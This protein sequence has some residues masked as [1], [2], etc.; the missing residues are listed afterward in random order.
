MIWLRMSAFAK[1]SQSKLIRLLVK[2]EVGEF[3]AMPGK[4]F[5]LIKLELDWILDPNQAQ[6]I[7]LLDRAA[8]SVG[9]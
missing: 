7:S 1:N 3:E 5:T 6:I 4:S 2:H 8:W 9:P